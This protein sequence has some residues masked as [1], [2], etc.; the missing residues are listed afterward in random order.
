MTILYA[1]L[2]KF[3]TRGSREEDSYSQVTKFVNFRTL[4]PRLMLIQR[5]CTLTSLFAK[6]VKSHSPD[7]TQEKHTEYE[8]IFI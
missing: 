7:D 4:T 3:G 1:V 8:D 5:L 6:T 2:A